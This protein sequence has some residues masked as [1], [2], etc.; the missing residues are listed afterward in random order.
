MKLEEVEI[1]PYPSWLGNDLINHKLPWEKGL[2]I[3][4]SEFSKTYTIHDSCWTGLYFDVPNCSSAILIIQW[5][6]HWLPDSIILNNSCIY[7]LIKLKQVNDVLT[8]GDFDEYSSQGFICSHEIET[9][10]EQQLLTIN[11]CARG[12]VEI[13]FSGETTFLALDRDRK[14]IDI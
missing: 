13:T 5:D 2:Q 8:S 7:L 3:G 14:I 11:S 1:D 12:I 4:F 9:V 10:D 6:D